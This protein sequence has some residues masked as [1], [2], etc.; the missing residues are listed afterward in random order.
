MKKLIGCSLVLGGLLVIPLVL[1]TFFLLLSATV[2]SLPAAAAAFAWDRFASLFDDSAWKDA[3]RTVA[4][5]QMP[6][7]R[8][9]LLLYRP[10]WADGKKVADDDPAHWMNYGRWDNSIFR[11]PMGEHS[12]TFDLGKEAQLDEIVALAVCKKCSLAVY[13]SPDNPRDPGTNQVLGPDEVAAYY[14][15]DKGHVK[16]NDPPDRRAAAWSIGSAKSGARYLTLSTRNEDNDAYVV[17]LLAFPPGSRNN[18]LWAA[19]S[20]L[21]DAR[22]RGIYGGRL[23]QSLGQ[24]SSFH[25]LG[26]GQD[27]LS[28]SP[29]IHDGNNSAFSF[30]ASGADANTSKNNYL[31]VYPVVGSSPAHAGDGTVGDTSASYRTV[32]L[33]YRLSPDTVGKID[34]IGLAWL[35]GYGVGISPLPGA[36]GE[37]G[38]SVSSGGG[39]VS[40][41]TSSPVSST[42]TSTIGVSP[43]PTPSPSPIASPTPSPVISSTLLPPRSKKW[44]VYLLNS[45]EVGDQTVLSSLFSGGV[46]SVP[47]PSALA[48]YEL[49]ALDANLTTTGSLNLPDGDKRDYVV[50]SFEES[51][52]LP[53]TPPAQLSTGLSGLPPEWVSLSQLYLNE[54]KPP[55]PTTWPRSAGG[56]TSTGPSGAGGR[57]DISTGTITADQIDQIVSQPEWNWRGIQGGYSGGEAAQPSKL[58]GLGSFYV[59]M[60]QKYGINPA[61][62]LAWARKETSLGTTGYAVYDSS[63]SHWG[64]NLYN[65]SVHDNGGSG[66][67]AN[68]KCITPP[69]NGTNFRFCSYASFQDSVEEYFILLKAYYD[70]TIL[71]QDD[72]VKN[73]CLWD[74]QGHKVS[75]G[76][77]YPRKACPCRT[78]LAILDWYAPRTENDTELYANQIQTWVGTDWHAAGS[79]LVN[80][81]GGRPVDNISYISQTDLS[82]YSNP[83]TRNMS[84]STCGMTS[85]T[86]VINSYGFNF[87]IQD[88]LEVAMPQ[89]GIYPNSPDTPQGKNDGTYHFRWIHSAPMLAD[90]PDLKIQDFLGTP[91]ERISNIRQHI[92][93]GY[94]MIVNLVNHFIVVD[95]YNAGDNTFLVYDPYP[96][97]TGITIDRGIKKWT[98][99]ELQDNLSP[100]HRDVWVSPSSLPL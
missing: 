88:I 14:A 30:Y 89:G 51:T 63:N 56:Y 72:V 40:T 58:I 52:Y 48:N 87:R 25:L 84:E 11:L 73:A 43:S 2:V 57:Y 7:N 68:G 90:G 20:A 35:T 12:Y 22:Y 8:E 3:V 79:P 1:L 16:I 98:A 70:G 23:T 54:K 66:L 34:E 59:Q 92:G 50:F 41:A 55:V 6:N 46:D 10:L 27:V 32:Y 4:S 21:F 49:K 67:W 85:A 97:R 5:Y 83:T 96:W 44:R 74:G 28:T 29:A 36:I 78:P 45:A 15:P 9:D 95:G 93:D 82:Q 18:A 13:Y 39:S 24:P 76:I 61:Y 71:K 17:Q 26:A 62:A 60:G 75:C 42:V 86:M 31:P 80:S 69:A 94:P 77:D 19:Q 99:K 37:G 53:S 100:G 64:Y 91:P 81:G 33:G 65:I 47:E 38:S